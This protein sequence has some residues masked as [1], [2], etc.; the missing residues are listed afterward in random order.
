M[1]SSEE[2]RL[3]VRGYVESEA[4]L[5]VAVN[6]SKFTFS[7]SCKAYK[8]E[9]DAVSFWIGGGED[10]AI[11]FDLTGC[12]FEFRDIPVGH[13]NLPVG[14]KAVSC[15]AAARLEDDFELLI[16]LLMC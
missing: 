3:L 11:S 7:G 15:L 16:I 13:P 2:A 14:R 9:L 4:P 6:A 5:R 12:F 1:V 8:V 10:S